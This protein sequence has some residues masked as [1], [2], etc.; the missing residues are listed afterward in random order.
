MHHHL[1][2]EVD[3][4]VHGM[5]P[6]STYLPLLQPLVTESDVRSTDEEPVGFLCP[7]KDVNILDIPDCLTSYFVPLGR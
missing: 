1:I 5:H 7:L 2:I 6:H 3:R 4:A